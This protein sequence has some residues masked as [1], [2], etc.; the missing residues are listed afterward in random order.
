MC[1]TLNSVR[2]IVKYAEA[3]E[4]QLRLE[5]DDMISSAQSISTT[6]I[7]ARQIS[8]RTIRQAAHEFEQFVEHRGYGQSR[9]FYVL[10]PAYPKDY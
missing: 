2:A 6:L 10:I 7:S 8:R 3:L 1:V 4:Q 5:P 9:I